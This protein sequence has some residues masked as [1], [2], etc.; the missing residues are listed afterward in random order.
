MGKF[1]RSL[2]QKIADGVAK[3]CDENKMKLNVKKC[4]I[5]TSNYKPDQQ[6]MIKGEPLEEVTSYKYL[7]I[8][9]NNKLNWDQQWTRVKNI[10][11]SVPYLIKRLKQQGW[12]E[13]ILITI[14]RSHALSHF[15]YSAPTLTSASL[16][17]K[18]EMERFQK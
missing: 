5:I 16:S 18:H 14:Y 13:P 17:A 7:G 8:E 4:K 11:S 3:W 12:P 6:I 9:L 2:P 1:N 15:I 10:T